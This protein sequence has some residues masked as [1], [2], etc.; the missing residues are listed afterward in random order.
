MRRS[1]AQGTYADNESVD[2]GINDAFNYAIGYTVKAT[3]GSTS[4]A[5]ITDPGRKIYPFVSWKAKGMQER[6]ITS[7]SGIELSDDPLAGENEFL[8]RSDWCFLTGVYDASRQRL[9]MYLDGE[10]HG[11]LDIVTDTTAAAQC[12]TD[13][14]KLGKSY[15]TYVKLGEN[16]GN[17]LAGPATTTER[18]LL[19]EVRIWGVAP[20]TVALTGSADNY[21]TNFVRSAH[22][23]A[24][25]ARRPVTPVFGLYD[26]SI[27]DRYQVAHSG[28]LPVQPNRHAYTVDRRVSDNPW[29]TRPGTPGT[30][31]RVSYLDM[32]NNDR[33]EPGEN[34][35]RDRTVAQALEEDQYNEDFDEANYEATDDIGLLVMT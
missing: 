14:K 35:W 13:A 29:R 18:L 8:Y 24:D 15:Q 21:I 12:P 22:E 26:P 6:R 32:N 10:T 25:G 5:G 28:G 23:I 20:H 1:L 3:D 31:V 9:T 33:W 34:I 7:A 30:Y 4:T 11:F 27:G 2:V 19:D 16:L 17:V